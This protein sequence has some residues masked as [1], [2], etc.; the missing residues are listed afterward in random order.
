LFRTN[1]VKSLLKLFGLVFVRGGGGDEFGL[2]NLSGLTEMTVEEGIGSRQTDGV[3][4]TAVPEFDEGL[5]RGEGFE[6]ESGGYD[7]AGLVVQD[8]EE[9]LL[10]PRLTTEL[11]KVSVGVLA[12]TGDWFISLIELAAQ[13][14][15]HVTY[16]ASLGEQVHDNAVPGGL[17]I[18]PHIPPWGGALKGN[19]TLFSHFLLGLNEIHV[20]WLH[21][22]LT[23]LGPSD[24][25]WDHFR[26]CQYL[27]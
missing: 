9:S 27:A 22:F 13:L 5:H 6:L 16:C 23:L 26:L 15:V 14:F 20:R 25:A 10:K 21:L 17:L 2:G 1:T 12:G 19:Q 11:D 7:I 8:L 18:N 24:T 3:S 4:V